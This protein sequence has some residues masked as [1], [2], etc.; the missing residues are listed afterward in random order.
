MDIQ[1][2]K[3]RLVSLTVT[4][5]CNL[6]CLYCYER[7][8]K[9]TCM[10]I[11]VAKDAIAHEFATCTGYDEI[12]ID[13][14]GGEP[15][16]YPEFIQEL[17]DWTAS[18]HFGK[19]YVFFLQT[20]GTLVHGKFQEWLR[21]RKALVNVGLS[22]DGTPETHNLNRCA[23]Y[24]DIDIPFFVNN[25]PKQGVRMTVND[26][27]FQ[28]LAS[29]VI[30]LH[31][32][33]FLRVDAVFAYGRNWNTEAV[34]LGL[35][36][37]LRE[38]C[39]FYLRNPNLRECSIFDLDL[40]ILIHNQE[41]LEKWCGSGETMVS[42]GV[43]G[44]RYPCQTFQPNTN[45]NPMLLGDIDFSA[46]RD[47]SDSACGQCLMKAICPTC[48]GINHLTSGNILVRNQNW[49]MV[50]KLRTLAKSYLCARQIEAR[51][52]EM[53]PSMVYQT[54]RAIQLVQSSLANSLPRENAL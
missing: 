20:N 41:N 39:D 2:K 52:R 12:E 21:Q 32:L 13:L 18:Q 44:K 48:Y 22:L 19:A 47:F 11:D 28:N 23:S 38:L 8:K 9:N 37:E 50:T 10:P 15:T 45:P 5:N 3:R 29:D 31:N 30:H 54:I 53:S 1:D 25:Y 4:D 7:D 33:G 14:F 34:E 42:I 36:R 17:V 27:T 46:I 24:D 35:S 16:L 6:D 51:Y 49:C 26:G 43:D 40:N